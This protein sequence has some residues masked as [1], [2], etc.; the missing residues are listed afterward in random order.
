MP[1]T[2]TTRN[3]PCPCGSG[4]RFK[5]CHGQAESNESHPADAP[6][7][8]VVAGAQRCGTTTLDLYLRTHPRLAMPV[9]RKELHFF[10]DDARFR[11]GDV[12]Y[13]AYHA[14]F[15]PR[16]AGQLRGEVTPSYVYWTPACERLAQYSAALRIVIVLRNPITRAY[17]HWNKE[18]QRGREPLPFQDAL[19]AERERAAA[20]AT[21][22]DRRTSYAGR[23]FYAA[24]LRRLWQHFPQ[25]QTLVLRSEALQHDPA[26]ALA[27]V[28][29]F[30]GIGAFPAS[31]PI[32]ANARR[33]E[34]PMRNDEWEWLAQ[35]LAG[36]VR[37]VE[38]LLGWDCSDWLR[39]P[40]PAAGG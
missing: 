11:G 28:G 17:S 22:Q 25:R 7:D 18:R 19:R 1:T 15:A 4:R 9:T 27:R 3:A 16:R 6:V 10:D 35:R 38:A 31:A 13:R 34:R 29:E 40:V 26:Q 21:G 14:N 32:S 39:P 2:A 30:L 5:H 36:D 24:Q 12:D 20:A 33:Y 23:G 8:F 37:D